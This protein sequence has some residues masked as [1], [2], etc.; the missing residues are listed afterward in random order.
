MWNAIKFWWNP[1]AFY[2]GN[3]YHLKKWAK[4]IYKRDNYT[5]QKCGAVGVYRFGRWEGMKF[6]AH[7]KR[8]KSIY[9]KLVF[10]L[11]N[12]IT[13]CEPCHTRYHKIFGLGDLPNL[14]DFI[15]N[16]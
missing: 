13:L 16:Y 2:K 3:L 5:C 6:H 14:I 10:K 7:H 11:D 15:K 8:P 4:L 1:K 12:G 9:P